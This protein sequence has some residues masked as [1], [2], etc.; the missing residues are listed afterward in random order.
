MATSN[1]VLN[2]GFVPQSEKD[3]AELFGRAVT[4]TPRPAETFFLESTAFSKGGG[5]TV[6]YHVPTEE[7]SILHVPFAREEDEVL[8][9]LSG[10]L[11]GIVTEGE[12]KVG[13]EGESLL[14]VKRGAAVFVGAGAQLKISKGVELWAAFYDS[15]TERETGPS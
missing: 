5:K 1:N 4:C 7:F 6:V 13:E 14:D 2:V 11:I 8:E 9:P 12:G 3:S 10:P 15:E